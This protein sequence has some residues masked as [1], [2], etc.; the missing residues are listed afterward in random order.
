MID[1]LI[2]IYKNEKNTNQL[3]KYPNNIINKTKDILFNQL[4]F[5][6]INQLNIEWI[7]F[8]NIYELEYERYNYFLSQILITR[9]RKIIKYI[10]SD[11]LINEFLS[12]NE[13]NFRKKYI[14]L[15]ELNSFN[16][17]FNKNDLKNEIIAFICTYNIGMYLIDGN[18]I[19]LKEGEFYVC[20]I[21]DVEK[22]IH[23]G[24][25]EIV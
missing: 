21:N 22:L 12:E 1:D 14:N 3:L 23:D 2:F 8:L 6:K 24:S 16:D 10:Y 18:E 9:L 4:E 11:D 19:C 17:E 25:I 5:I 20:S 7:D 13:L 15:M